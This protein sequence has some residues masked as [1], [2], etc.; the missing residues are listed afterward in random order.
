[1]PFWL[2]FK[3]LQYVGAVSSEAKEWIS[4]TYIYKRTPYIHMIQTNV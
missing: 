1:M 2:L 4:H 3:D